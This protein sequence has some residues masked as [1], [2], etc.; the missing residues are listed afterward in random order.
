MT[1]GETRGLDL[2]MASPDWTKNELILA[3]HLYMGSGV[4]PPTSQVEELSE[5][6]RST[7]PD[8]IDTKFRSPDSI[9]YKLQNFQ[10]L[11]PGSE[12]RGKEHG[13]ELDR[14]VWTEFAGDHDRLT[15]EANAIR[16][17]M[18]AVPG[19][20][21]FENDLSEI[22]AAKIAEG[23]TGYRW[24]AADEYVQERLAIPASP[25][26]PLR[27][28]WKR[29]DKGGRRYN[30]L[31]ESTNAA[32][33]RATVVFIVVHGGET[34]E[35]VMK[36][37]LRDLRGAPQ[38]AGAV[39]MISEDGDGWRVRAIVS[40][41]ND[42]ALDVLKSAFPAAA[43]NLTVLEGGSLMGPL[44]DDTTDERLTQCL[45]EFIAFA[46]R[47]GLRLDKSSSIDLLAATLAS[48]FLLFSGP[49]GT[50][51][52]M[53]A[54][55]LAD[56]FAPKFA[57][58]L[59]EGR[60]HWIGPE[61]VVGFFSSINSTFLDTQFTSE[62]RRLSQFGDA[63][64]A[65]ASRAAAGATPFLLVEEANL[66]PIEGYL[67]PIFHG[68]SKPSAPD[69]RWSLS[70]TGVPGESDVNDNLRLGPFLRVLGTINVDATAP[71][72]ARKVTSRAAVMLIEPVPMPEAGEL[73]E[74]LSKANVDWE[75]EDSF[76]ASVIQDPLAILAVATDDRKTACIHVLAES[77]AKLGALRA[78]RRDV[79]RCVLFML[80]FEGLAS[81]VTD[82]A[83]GPQAVR[84]LAAENALLHYILPGL[85]PA[86]F[87]Q[88]LH[89]LSSDDLRS[90]S[91]TGLAGLLL[92][93]I[94]RLRATMEG[95]QG[96][97]G[98]MDFW[99]AL[100]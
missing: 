95:A 46:G 85:P 82:E 83:G 69:V 62:I 68:V 41:H 37:V 50:G 76:G 13:G 79:D 16:H 39:A 72:P 45:D 18:I 2:S 48:Q 89:T 9:R 67:S 63:E 42:A 94:E 3:L 11:D 8:L 15:A 10:F 53:T 4:S 93:R 21:N 36:N 40:H 35:A 57:Q 88:A 5:L 90:P 65:D 43:Q 6:L 74:T 97:E 84:H 49:S 26:R 34:I 70:A 1:Q 7:R 92:P 28:R 12:G 20:T 99:N 80:W 78:S 64:V 23:G 52:S 100:S 47:R 31:Q 73:L 87:R 60:R 24:K 38:V 56:F 59:I 17:S 29:T 27:T 61:D 75:D 25:G 71:S 44:R 51:K 55:V 22:I 77:L 32:N 14:Q 86:G 54:R 33:T 30:V 91:A 81:S 98:A 66:S 58:G 96:F 19:P